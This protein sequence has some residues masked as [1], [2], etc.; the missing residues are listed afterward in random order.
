MSR[1]E[2]YR[3]SSNDPSRKRQMVSD[4]RGGTGRRY[5]DESL[6]NKRESSS[7]NTN[8]SKPSEIAIS[9]NPEKVHMRNYLQ[10]MDKDSI[11][12]WIAEL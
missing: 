8:K 7:D 12:Q 6:T 2:S 11:H 1:R 9:D 10:L 3:E 4:S 5:E